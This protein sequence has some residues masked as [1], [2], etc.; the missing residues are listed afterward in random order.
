MILVCI[1]CKKEYD[2]PK[3]NRSFC[4]RKCSI[5]NRK[6]DHDYL[7][8]LKGPKK[9]RTTENVNCKYCNEPFSTK[10][11][12]KYCSTACNNRDR[13]LGKGYLKPTPCPTCG[14]E[15]KP[16]RGSRLYCSIK[17]S[18]E[19]KKDNPTFLAALSAGC[20]KRSENKE[21]LEKLST[22]AKQRWRDPSF[23]EKMRDIFNSEEWLDKST[24]NFYTK[25]YVFPSGK[26]VKVQGYEDKFIDEL[27]NRCVEE[28]IIVDKKEI[29]REIGRIEYLD[30]DGKKHIYVPD[31]YVKSENKVYE[32]KSCWTY[33]VNLE[34]NHKKRDAVLSKG[35]DFE[36]VIR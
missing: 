8:K 11:S 36:F 5:D 3:T 25:D 26:V 15:F 23:S 34:I 35:I 12:Q 18:T 1:E 24:N 9:Q 30:K 17:C 6:K 27:L 33:E 10:T 14:Q 20:K 22:K 4:S 31:I 29:K 13:L 32:V 2:S 28:D 16:V 19:A 21:Y 7:K